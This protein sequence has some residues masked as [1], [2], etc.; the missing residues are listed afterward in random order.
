MQIPSLADCEI[1]QQI[2]GGMR[3]Q[4]H[5]DQR[6]ENFARFCEMNVVSRQI[7]KAK[8]AQFA[9]QRRIGL[10][11]VNERGEIRFAALNEGKRHDARR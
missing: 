5:S 3:L 4:R 8:L 11:V 7:K 2:V 10:E 9:K 6:M 1:S